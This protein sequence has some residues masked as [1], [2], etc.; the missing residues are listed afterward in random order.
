L[1]LTMTACGC[2]EHVE[3]SVV[4]QEYSTVKVSLSLM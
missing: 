1:D 3:V 2:G 4:W